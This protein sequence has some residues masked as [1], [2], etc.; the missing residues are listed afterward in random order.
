MRPSSTATDPLVQ[1]AA[2]TAA[3]HLLDPEIKVRR[4]RLSRW[5][6]S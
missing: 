5:N 4:C 2:E 6:P 3:R 1:A